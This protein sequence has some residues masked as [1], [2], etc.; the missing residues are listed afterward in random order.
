M[1]KRRKGLS[2]KMYWELSILIIREKKEIYK[3]IIRFV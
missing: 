1:E 3:A 2:K